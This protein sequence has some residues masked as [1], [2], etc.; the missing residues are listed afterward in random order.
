MFDNH[1]EIVQNTPETA[2]ENEVRDTSAEAL[3]ACDDGNETDADD[4][5]SQF[6]CETTQEAVPF[7]CREVKCRPYEDVDGNT[8]DSVMFM[9]SLEY[10]APHI[11]PTGTAGVGKGKRGYKNKLFGESAFGTQL[12]LADSGMLPDLEAENVRKH[13]PVWLA[14]NFRCYKFDRQG[15]QVFDKKTGAAVTWFGDVRLV[16]GGQAEVDAAADKFEH[17][18]NAK[19][20]KRSKGSSSGD[21]KLKG[22]T[23]AMQFDPEH[24]EGWTDEELETL[25]VAKQGNIEPWLRVLLARTEAAEDAEAK[26]FRGIIHDRDVRD[27]YWKPELNGGAGG[28]V[29]N[30]PKEIHGHVMGELNG[31]LSIDQYAAALGIAPNM[32]EKP[33]QGRYAMDNLRAYQIHAKDSKKAQ[34][35]PE[36]VVTLRGDDYVEIYNERKLAWERGAKVKIMQE[37][38]VDIEALINDCAEGRVTLDNIVLNDDYFMA[39]AQPDIQRRIDAALKAAGM[40]R[41]L[42]AAQSMRSTDGNVIWRKTVGYG[43]GCGGS[44]KTT[45]IEVIDAVFAAAYGWTTYICN[46]SN[47]GLESYAGEEIIVID[48]MESDFMSPSEWKRHLDNERI[49]GKKARYKDVPA[50]SARV[51]FILANDNLVDF[52]LGSLM[53]NRAAAAFL[54]AVARRIGIVFRIE[55][56]RDYGYYNV[57]F[58]VRR[59]VDSYSITLPKDSSFGDA[60][61]ISDLGVK[62]GADGLGECAP[63]GTKGMEG[64]ASYYALV[65]TLIRY[66]DANS[67]NNA[68]AESGQLEAAIDSAKR[69]LYR[70]FQQ[71]AK[72]GEYPTLPGPDDGCLEICP[73]ET[74]GYKGENHKYGLPGAPAVPSMGLPAPKGGD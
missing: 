4:D 57:W 19:R 64:R 43:F 67:A 3:D 31:K 17:R 61:V 32:I 41:M 28:Y 33:K 37:A 30:E 60:R 58:G 71:G 8:H 15:N 56:P 12:A 36:D 63:Y 29:E 11:D 65:D 51:W 39:Y 13:H 62:F 18:Q 24:Y 5:L 70:R 6:V 54:C 59:N 48:D 22:F 9:T 38:T 34:Y 47:N 2:D 53:F 40:R 35:S 25:D 1:E 66:V 74:F 42:R 26:E 69:N 44:G 49:A 72:T 50:L 16:E 7:Y 20:K 27:P 45:M 46:P 10:T 52:F 23:F 68:L 55:R 21:N 14:N 73:G